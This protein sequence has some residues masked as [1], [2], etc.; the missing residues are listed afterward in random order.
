MGEPV[1]LDVRE[2]GAVGD[3]VANDARAVLFDSVYERFDVR[4][5]DNEPRFDPH[6]GAVLHLPA[7][8]YRI[9][10]VAGFAR[11]HSFPF[12]RF[13]IRG[14]GA[15]RTTVLLDHREYPLAR[16]SIFRGADVSMAGLTVR[17]TIPSPGNR[18]T[19]EML[20]HL[21]EVD[22][23]ALTDLVVRD[24][25]RFGIHV[26]TAVHGRIAGCRAHDL[27]I[28]GI[29]LVAC[30]GVTIEGNDIRDTGDD[31]IAVAGG[32]AHNPGLSRNVV[33][34]DNLVRRAGSAGIS[35]NGCDGVLIEG[36]DVAGTY[37][38][39]IVL[40]PFP[41]YGAVHDVTIV[42][43]QVTEAGLHEE[44]V[45]WGGG[46]AA[47]IAVSDD[48]AVGVSI[49]DVA[50]ERNRIGRCRN[51]LI[52]VAHADNV[53]IRDNVL[54]GPLVPGPSPN[55]GSGEGSASLD[56]G[57]YEPVHVVDCHRVVTDAPAA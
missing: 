15:D 45:L 20:V 8:T 51:S 9:G 57:V 49:E 11:R 50:I 4:T 38:A 31:A 2:F 29:H 37:Q 42:D 30:A 16:L 28:D 7:G 39:G 14:D 26:C 47:G 19:G 3:G 5:W 25:P 13:H 44:G 48:L 27:H 34:R 43:N 33:V 55:Q 6:E 24:G 1:V 46:V 23:F 52:R 36:N 54:D 10:A 17:S 18:S 53:V 21:G 32:D 56:P 35:V 12:S 41:G 40:R 22:G